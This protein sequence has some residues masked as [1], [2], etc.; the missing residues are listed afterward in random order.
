MALALEPENEEANGLLREFLGDAS[1]RRKE[2]GLQVCTDS[3][4]KTDLCVIAK[5]IKCKLLD[6]GQ[7]VRR[8]SQR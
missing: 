3:T 2:M 1:C 8:N 7:S 5:V 6:K 4:V